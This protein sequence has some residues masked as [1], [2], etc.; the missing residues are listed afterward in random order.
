[1]FLGSAEFAAVKLLQAWCRRIQPLPR[2][3]CLDLN[4]MASVRYC[5]L[6]QAHRSLQ[7]LVKA[8]TSS[9]ILFVR[10]FPVQEQTLFLSHSLPRTAEEKEEE[11]G[12]RLAAKRILAELYKMYMPEFIVGVEKVSFNM[13]QTL[14]RV[15][16]CNVLQA[17]I[18]IVSYTKAAVIRFKYNTSPPVGSS[19]LR[20]FPSASSSTRLANHACHV[21]K[22]C[23]AAGKFN[24]ASQLL[25]LAA[26]DIELALARRRLRM[27]V[28]EL[29]RA[30]D[31]DVM[32]GVSSKELLLASNL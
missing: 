15:R 8:S 30:I 18:K 2:H 4:A 7:R 5:G 24:N 12:Q 27:K 3:P 26:D 32:M 22:D 25:Q 16:Y 11:G 19:L 17:S 23:L 20:F 13:L 28:L 31:R 9:T 14:S 29:N 1:M 21:A 10:T 6:I